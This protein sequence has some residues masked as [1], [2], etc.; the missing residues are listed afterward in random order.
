MAETCADCEKAARDFYV[1]YYE[2]SPTVLSTLSAVKSLQEMASFSHQAHLRGLSQ[3]DARTLAAAT[4][5]LRQRALAAEQI[6]K[7]VRYSDKTREDADADYHLLSGMASALESLQPACDALDAAKLAFGE[8]VREECAKLQ[9]K[10]LLPQPRPTI[11]ELEKILSEPAPEDVVEISPTGELTIHS[12][13][14][15]KI[16]AL[17]LK[18]LLSTVKEEK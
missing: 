11:E 17:D 8:L 3:G 15:D 18:A 5:F 16:R 9:E 7:D 12:Q 1:D 2:C 6:V 14:A 4:A 10:E 13:S